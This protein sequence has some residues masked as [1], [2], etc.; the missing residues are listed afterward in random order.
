MSNGN[1]ASSAGALAGIRVLDF[2]RVLAGPYCTMLLGDL[3]AEVIKVEHPNGGD[4]SRQFQPPALGGESTYFLQLNRNKKSVVLDLGTGEGK[5][6][7]RSLALRA[8]V[9]VENFR[10]GVMARLGLDYA[11]LKAENPGLVYCSIS[12]YG[13]T[14]QFAHRPGLDPVIQA[15]SGLMAMTGEP[16][17]QPM[18]T[19]MSLVDM[20]SGLYASHTITAALL[21][22]ANTGKGQ[23]VEVSLFGAGVN[24][25]ANFGS[26]YLMAGDAPKRPGNG[27]LVAQPS[28]LYH[29]A[30]GSLVLTAVGEPAFERF[31]A[32]VLDEPELANDPRFASNPA[33]LANVVALSALINARFAEHPRAYW[34]ERL[35]AA[36]I[37]GGGVRTVPEAM[38]S[39]EFANSALGAGVDHP[40]A[41]RLTVLLPPMTLSDTPLVHPRPAP[42]LGQHTDEVLAQMRA[43]AQDSGD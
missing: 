32:Q 27:N 4:P 12:G 37:P 10:P 24:M 13:T 23:A 40:T 22:R 33:R 9:L 38:D 36:G 31:C 2:T 34:L 28:D 25:L 43:D 21:H 20:T 41:G 26:T 7:A 19:G 11:A 42:T 14:G 15:E 6:L 39:P 3:G 18:R 30:D 16:D 1:D 8:D 5:A 29:A 17:G 35:A